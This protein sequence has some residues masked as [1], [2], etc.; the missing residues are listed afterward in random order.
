MA[1][2]RTAEPGARVVLRGPTT[3]CARAP[4]LTD[5]AHYLSTLQAVAHGAT[6]S[7]SLAAALGR[8]SRS[9]HHSLNGLVRAGFVESMGET[10]SIVLRGV[11]ITCET[12]GAQNHHR[13]ANG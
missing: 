7:G 2:D 11:S 9:V 5:R 13:A 10:V 1:V 3:S 6:T 12:L 4:Q 8:D